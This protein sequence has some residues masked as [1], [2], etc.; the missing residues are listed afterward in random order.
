MF[1]RWM[2]RRSYPDLGLYRS[3]SAAGLVVPLD[4]HMGRIGQNLGLTSRKI[5]DWKMAAQISA[6]LARL[7]PEDPL[8]YDFALTRPGILG[9][10]SGSY[11][12]EVCPRCPLRS[13][14]AQSRAFFT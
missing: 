5:R 11:Q 6:G 10:C 7:D 13:I 4:V 3:F 1:L 12:K 9:K 8:K 2:V 14:C